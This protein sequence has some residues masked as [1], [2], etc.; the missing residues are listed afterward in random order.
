[1]SDSASSVPTS[2]TASD[3]ERITALETK[4]TALIDLLKGAFSSVEDGG[5]GVVRQVFVLTDK[6]TE[7]DAL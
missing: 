2:S 1:M 6:K 5:S 7:M 3:S 4:L